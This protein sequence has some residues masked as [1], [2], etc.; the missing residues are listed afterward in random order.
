MRP[1]AWNR[2]RRER[3]ASEQGTPAPDSGGNAVRP[4]EAAVLG[5]NV[6]L[7]IVLVL[8]SIALNRQVFVLREA[9]GELPTIVTVNEVACP[10][11]CGCP[12]CPCSDNVVE[13]RK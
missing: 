11:K 9:M 1:L 12:N 10:C 3:R 2:V 6:G 7:M 13:A 8:A 4:V 5:A